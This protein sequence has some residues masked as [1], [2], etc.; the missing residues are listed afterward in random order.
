MKNY[1]NTTHIDKIEIEEVAD[2]LHYADRKADNGWNRR[3][4]A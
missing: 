4:R 1:F 2:L 3:V